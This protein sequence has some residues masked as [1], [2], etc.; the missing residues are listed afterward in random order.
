MNKNAKNAAWKRT[1]LA[2]ALGLATASGA[3]AAPELAGWAMLPAATFS[4]GPTSGRFAAQNPYGTE[5]LPLVDKQPVQ[6]FSGVLQGPTA[7]TF[8][9]MSDNGFGSKANSPDALLRVYA[10]KPDFRIFDGS[11]VVG[12]ATVA[13]ADYA[14]GASLPAFNSNSFITLSDP[15]HK[16][17][18]TLVADG[19]HY[20]YGGSGPG[21][22]TIPV[23]TGIQSGRLLTGGDFD[24]E[25]L[26]QDKNGNLW[27][28]DEFGPFLIKTD[29]TGKVLRQEIPLPG[30]TAP[31]NPYLGGGTPNLGTSRGFEGMAINP[32]GDKLYTLLEGTVA[33]DPAKS[34][35]IN[36]FDIDTERYTGTQ[37]LYP[38][39]ASGTA[40]GDMTAI[41][42]HQFLVLERNGD[43]ATAGTPFK[44]VYLA[45]TRVVDGSGFIQ[46]TPLVDLMNLADPHDLNGDGSTTFTFPY[47]TIED[48]LI[49][50]PTT[51]LILNDNNYPYGG[52]RGLFAD[53]NEFLLVKL[54]QPLNVA[55][56]PVPAALPLMLSGLAGVFGFARRRAA[57]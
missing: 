38:L 5:P 57:K 26:R 2:M 16:L 29:A 52:G 15:D 12:G 4:D 21:N 14:S 47:V 18:F 34:L 32:A 23:D 6:G 1:A 24:I 20:P 50:D 44:M 7:D 31:Q 43:T 40:I 19:T 54:D 25:S 28:G 3:Q 10:V 17:G 36:E 48:V 30:V 22:A 13:P 53:V 37:F 41:N 9:V 27:F 55:A 46:K 11:G 51:L 35:R 33:G 39:D 45:D 49:V 56:V 42:D 8:Y